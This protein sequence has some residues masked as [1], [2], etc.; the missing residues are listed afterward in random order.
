MAERA[1]GKSLND[2]MQEHVFKPLNIQKISM[3]PSADM[4]SRLVY[5]HSR[6]PET[7]KLS[8]REHI[9]HRALAVEPGSADEKVT[10]NS[11][12]AGCFAQ[13]SEYTKIIATLLNDGTDPVTKNQILKPE[14]IAEMFKNQIEHLPNFGRAGIPAAKPDYTHPLPDL[15]TK[16]HIRICTWRYLTNISCRPS[17]R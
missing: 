12:G 17:R 10:L 4:K 7:G 11:A 2:L 1:S 16:S 3:F 9:N 13:P 14:T 6:H 15:C 5:T 8:V